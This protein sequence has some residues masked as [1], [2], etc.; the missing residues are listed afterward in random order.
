M[1]FGSKAGYDSTLND[2]A[3][4]SAISDLMTNVLN[5]L[6]ER[7]WRSDILQIKG[8]QVIVSGGPSQGLQIGSRLAVETKGEVVTSGQSGLPITLPGSEVAK[9]EIISFFGEDSESEGA[10]AKIIEGTV[11]GEKSD[12]VIVEAK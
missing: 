7:R 8:Q 6:G 3:I 4:S 9:I 12:F 11:T 5:K 1:G 2:K 10:V